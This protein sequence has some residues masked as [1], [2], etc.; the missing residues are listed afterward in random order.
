M[1]LPVLAAI[2]G[3]LF[4][5][6]AFL[7]SGRRRWLWASA[8]VGGLA[9]SC[10]YTTVLIP[11]ILTV[12]WWLCEWRQRG[13]SG[14]GFVRITSRVALG[15][16][17]YLLVLLL[18]NLVVTG[19]AFMPL[20]Q[21][22]GDHPSIAAKLGGR[23]TPWIA[24]IYETSMPQDWVGF[25]TQTH[26]QMSGGPSYLLG[27]RRQTG[28]RY[29][30]LVALAVKVPLTF[31]LLLAG[32]AVMAARYESEGARTPRDG[33]LPLAM[34][35]FLTVAALG[36]TRNYGFRYLLPLAPLA[37]IWASRLGERPRRT[38]RLALGWRAWIVGIGLAGQAIA[39]ASVYPHELTYFNSLG[40]GPRG[41]RY[42]LSDSNLDWGQ[43]LKVLARLQRLEPKYRDLTLYYFGDTDPARYGVRGTAYVVNAVDD[44][45]RLPELSKVKT[46][47]LAVSASLQ[48]GPWG[49]SGFFRD[50]NE[51]EPE[52]FTAD[53]TIAI[54]RLADLRGRTSKAESGLSRQ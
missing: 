34:A 25:A 6:W 38:R 12:A 32:R 53:T 1:E 13:A 41:G 30:Y 54:Y 16:S 18:A 10:K 5:F 24:R 37:I 40:G 47:Y 19:V 44:Q 28:W 21:S 3:M 26:H 11:P 36:S 27:E 20:S 22:K 39:V 8:A 51:V 29:Y 52:R 46:R 4:L 42:L 15:M 33:I 7:T 43:G 35:L 2:T 31:W 14:A 23:F 50:L 48:W 45:S 49:P 17:G 9:F